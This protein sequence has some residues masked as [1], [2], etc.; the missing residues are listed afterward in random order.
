[1]MREALAVY[2]RVLRSHRMRLPPPLRELGDGY[3]RDEFRRLRTKHVKGEVDKQRWS[4]FL[5]QWHAYCDALSN[6]PASSASSNANSGSPLEGLVD[7]S[8]NLRDMLSACSATT[9]ASASPSFVMSSVPL[10]KITVD[11]PTTLLR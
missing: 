1:M 10:M 5:K 4:E 3:A 6:D 9:N 2:A 11:S 8:G 7:Q